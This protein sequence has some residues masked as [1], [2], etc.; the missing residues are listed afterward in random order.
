MFSALVLYILDLYMPYV[1]Y[2]HT[3]VYVQAYK[4]DSRKPAG[5]GSLSILIFLFKIKKEEE[6]TVQYVADIAHG[7]KERG[8]FKTYNTQRAF[9]SRNVG[10]LSSHSWNRSRLEAG[11]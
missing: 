5:Q 4:S 1:C 6:S 8:F 11:R 3:F 2:T 10:L 7:F 9:F